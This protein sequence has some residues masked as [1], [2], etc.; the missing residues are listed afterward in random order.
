MKQ[1]PYI[2]FRLLCAV[3]IMVAAGIATAAA[4]SSEPKTVADFLLLVPDR[5]MDGYD[6]Q[7]REELLRGERRG[8]I[9]DIANGYISYDESDNPA[10]F[11]LAIF[12]RSDGSYLVAYS[13]GAFG[14]PELDK[15]L[16]NTP[17]FYLLSYHKGR[18]RD[19]TRS[20][21]PVPFDKRLAYH[22]PRQGKTIAVVNTRGRK[23]YDLTW[24]GDRFQVSRAVR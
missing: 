23:L 19:V 7:L 6:R 24:R 13:S 1:T 16:G 4:Q 12:K 18:W 5:Y 10:G 2:I 22:L 9:I 11:E 17:T 15:E 8:G 14:D 21:L 20:T 3:T